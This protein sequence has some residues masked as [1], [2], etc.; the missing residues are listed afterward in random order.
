MNKF[1]KFKDWFSGNILYFDKLD[2]SWYC[3]ILG[4]FMEINY[5]SE[6]PENLFELECSKIVK[7]FTIGIYKLTVCVAIPSFVKLDF[8]WQFGKLD[9]KK[10]S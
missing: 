10:A 2:N 1:K 5:S 6:I 8:Y 9:N 3:H 4:N 7:R